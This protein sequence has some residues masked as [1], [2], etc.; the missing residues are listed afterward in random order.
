MALL[1]VQ[2]FTSQGTTNVDTALDLCATDL[3]MCNMFSSEF[4]F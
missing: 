2:S 4:Q 3:T 1:P